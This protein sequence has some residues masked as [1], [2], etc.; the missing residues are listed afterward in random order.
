MR[1]IAEMIRVSGHIGLRHCATAVAMLAAST[2]AADNVAPLKPPVGAVEVLSVD[3]SLVLVV[4]VILIVGWLY[5]RAQGIR[6]GN[7]DAISIVAAQSLGPKERILVVDI[8]GEQ[9]V[10]GMTSTQISVLHVLKGRVE[11]NAAT[12]VSG[13]FADRFRDALR[14]MGK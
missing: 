6:G 7:N 12:S 9:L 1:S 2:A 10:V 4:G 14:G 3:T 8:A 5:S 11:K 13:S